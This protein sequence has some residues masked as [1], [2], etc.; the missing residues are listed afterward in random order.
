LPLFWAG[1]QSN[2]KVDEVEDGGR[3]IATEEG[4][5]AMVF[6]YAK[7]YNWLEGK[8]SVS[9]EVLRMIQN[10]TMH[11]EVSICT[12]GEW[13]SAIIKGFA[14][15]REVKNRGSGTLVVDLDERS[16]VLK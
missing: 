5:S 3:A 6:A 13:E 4:V 11:L 12:S 9:T 10:M 16:I 2:K 7:D 1:R 15:W 8:S 14:A